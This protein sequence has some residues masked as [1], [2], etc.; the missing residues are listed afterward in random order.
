MLA[1]QVW[2]LSQRPHCFLVRPS[3]KSLGEAL[4][5][6]SYAR[7]QLLLFYFALCFLFT[8]FCDAVT[9]T[10]HLG[11]G[12]GN[13]LFSLFTRPSSDDRRRKKGCHH[14]ENLRLSYDP[15]STISFR[16]NSEAKGK[17]VI[18]QL[19]EEG[20]FVGT[21]IIGPKEEGAERER[22]LGDPWLYEHGKGRQ[23]TA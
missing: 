15:D 13:S 14:R 3:F 8:F 5:V 7:I 20:K 16:C 17:E 18:V 4:F 6:F 19:A 11:A 9:T 2:S 21:S 22:C 12:N 10:R 23:T 1:T